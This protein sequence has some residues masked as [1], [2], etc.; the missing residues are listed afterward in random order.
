MPQN[1]S[2]VRHL[3]IAERDEGQ[4]VDNFLLRVLKGVPRSHVYRLLRSGQVRVNGGRVKPDRRLCVG[5]QLRLPPVATAAPREV[6]RAPDELLSRVVSSVVHED[7]DF[8]VLNK[9]ADMPVHGGTGV[10]YGLIEVLRQARSQDEFLELGHRLDYETS[11]CLVVARRRVALQAFHN[12]LR[13]GKAEKLYSALLVGRWEGTEREVNLS[14]HKSKSARDECHVQ[15][16]V[17]GRQARSL[18]LPELH[19]KTSAGIELSLMNIRIFTGRTH[20][21][22]VHAAHLGHPVAGDGK[23][24]DFEANRALRGGGL[25]RMFLH[26]SSLK[27]ELPGLSRS[28]DAQVPLPEDLQLLLSKLRG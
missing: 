3:Q 26:A 20:Q 5:D 15:V 25:K 21:I 16:D 22:R 9:P 24:G 8:L 13:L 7:D 2:P 27:M 1:Q 28:F 14:L 23:Y 17:A 10:A 19:L 6:Q 11:G 18:F 4:R 12:A